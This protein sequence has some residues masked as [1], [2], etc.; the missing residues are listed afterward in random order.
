MPSPSP[1]PDS[2]LRA[3]G[4][5]VASAGASQGQLRGPS[6]GLGA[7]VGVGVGLRQ[8]LP[9][10]RMPPPS[11]AVAAWDIAGPGQAHARQM[12]RMACAYASY[13]RRNQLLRHL[14]TAGHA[15]SPV[16]LYTPACMGC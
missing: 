1:I 4:A 6:R 9:R 5:R 14:K 8:V 7:G 10:C 12:F 3:S 13:T 2:R 11:T 15:A 16:V